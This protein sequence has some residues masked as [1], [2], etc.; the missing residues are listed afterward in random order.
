MIRLIFWIFIGL[1]ALSLFGVSLQSI[2]ESPLN[3]Q[4]FAYFYGITADGMKNLMT[5]IGAFFVD[6]QTNLPNLTDLFNN[7]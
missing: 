4:N 1:V 6:W 2:I 3:Q 5:L 7:K